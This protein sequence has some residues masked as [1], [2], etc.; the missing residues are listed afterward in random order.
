VSEPGCPFCQPR[1]DLVFH[2]GELV[3][4]LW[5]AFP[6]SP[7]HALLVPKRHVASWFEATDGERNDLIAT[8]DVARRAVVARHSPGGF[9]IGVNVGAAAGQTVF[10]LH[11]HLIPR[12]AGDVPDP[13]G[14][15]RYVIPARA[16][17]LDQTR[18]I[19]DT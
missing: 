17:Y 9:N 11:V 2:R 15:I 8:L 12:Y 5:D 16:N 19:G 18:G 14:G 7:G 3:L 13:R 4:A 10:H 6:A 1:D